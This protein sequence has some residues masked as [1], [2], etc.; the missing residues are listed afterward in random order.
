MHCPKCK[1]NQK[2]KNGFA[3]EKQRYKCRDC[4]CNYTQS[5][6]HRIPVERRVEAIK[7]YLESVGFRG[8]ERLTGISN[9][10]VMRWVRK[11]GGK[12]GQETVTKKQV[13]VMELDELWHFIGK[14]SINSGCG[15]RMTVTEDEA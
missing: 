4:G 9:V 10:T 7:L 13:S 8:I 11:L 2:V 15:L 1:S 12:I 14:K 6:I 3:R 5:D